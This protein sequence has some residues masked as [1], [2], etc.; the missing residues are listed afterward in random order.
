MPATGFSLPCGLPASRGFSGQ[1]RRPDVKNLPSGTG[2]RSGIHRLIALALICSSPV[3]VAEESASDAT[4]DKWSRSISVGLA[5]APSYFGDDQIQGVVLPD[6]R[7]EYGDRFRASLLSGAKF[8][9]FEHGRW[10]AGPTLRYDFGREEQNGSPFAIFGADSDDLLGLGDVKGSFEAGGFLSYDGGRWQSTVEMRHGLDGGHNGLVGTLDFK[11]SSEHTLLG[12]R[13]RLKIG[14]ELLYAD[15]DY[16]EAY[17]GVTPDQSLASGLAAYS[18]GAGI[19]R[20][21]IRANLLVPLSRKTS[22][23]VF[24]NFDRL[25]SAAANS[26][27]ITERGAENQLV[28]GLL[29][30][31]RL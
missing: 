22:L 23:G 21:G 3:V 7:I 13:S 11:Y 17:F 4:I 18:A 30:A 2:N 1:H 27:L 15:K 14:P 19:V 31:R 6:I 9:L 25:G 5:A 28:A 20:Y 24:A 16:S 12:R 10:S 8:T 26:S 29:I